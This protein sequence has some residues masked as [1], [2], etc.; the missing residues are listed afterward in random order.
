MAV[1]PDY[2]FIAVFNI[3]QEEG[4]IRR[5]PRWSTPLNDSN[6][7]SARGEKRRRRLANGAISTNDDPLRHETFPFWSIGPL[8]LK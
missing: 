7:I 2:R 3:C 5:Q 6:D 1:D 8:A 4:A